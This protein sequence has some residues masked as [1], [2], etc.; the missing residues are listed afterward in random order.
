MT[1]MYVKPI[2]SHPFQSLRPSAAVVPRIAFALGMAAREG[3]D[4]FAGLQRSQQPGPQG[5]A[6][7]PLKK[8]REQSLPKRERYSMGKGRCYEISP[9]VIQVKLHAARRDTEK[10]SNILH[11]LAIRDPGETLP[12]ALS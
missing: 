5:N 8:L 2:D 12:L 1:P 4:P 10:Y 3:E 6:Q 11:C 7:F 9:G